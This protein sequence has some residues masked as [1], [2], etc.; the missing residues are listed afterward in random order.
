VLARLVAEGPTARE[1]EKAKNQ[2]EAHFVR[3]FRTNNGVG[4]ALGYYEHIY[5]DYRKL[6]DTV[7]RYRAV[8]VADCKR[9][10]KEVF[11][12]RHRTVVELKPEKEAAATAAAT[13]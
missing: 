13:R 12:R 10:A 7:P 11:D 6:F 5:G 3:D 4:Q 1:L 9:V 2:L 8:T